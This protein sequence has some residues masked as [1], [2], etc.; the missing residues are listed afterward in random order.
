MKTTAS[1]IRGIGLGM[2]AGAAVTAA[3]MPVDKRRFMRSRAGRVVKN[4][5]QA[6]QSITDTFQ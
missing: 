1:L 2:I 6:A 3:V 5:G 4:I